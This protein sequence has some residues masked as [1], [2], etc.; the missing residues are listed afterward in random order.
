MSS[1]IERVNAF[2]R[3]A[4][5]SADFGVLFEALCIDLAGAGV[6]LWRV[7]IGHRTLDPVVRAHSDVWERGGGVSRHVVRH[8][9]GDEQ[10]VQS[11]IHFLWT[12]Q[13]T[14]GRWRLASGEDSGLDLLVDMRKR[15]GTDYVMHIAV[16]GPDAAEVDG[17]A[18]SFATDRPGGFSDDDLATIAAFVPAL[19]LASARAIASD[20]ARSTLGAY[21]GPRSA[22]LVLDGEIR[23]GQG[24]RAEAAILLTDLRGFTRLTDGTDPLAVVAWLDH[25][26]EAIV[27][28]IAARG[29]EVLKFMGDGLLAAFPAASRVAAQ[30]AC[31]RALVAARH[32]QEANA[33]LAGPPGAACAPSLDIALHYGEVVY[34]NVGAP[35][36]LDFTVI[37][38]AVNEASRIEALC[39][40][41]GRPILLSCAFARRCDQ[42]TV[43][44]GDHRLR[45]V[46][47][48]QAIF[49]PA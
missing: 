47:Q 48:A 22:Q 8:G 18:I 16:F 10:Y 2:L 21:L 9:E 34:G 31:T 1:P 17:S 45:G 3:R 15:G 30:D 6:P 40:P 25:H 4:T 46:E 23:R 35:D 19:G 27:P 39:E 41:L 5:E 29:G 12:R 37:G 49:A 24:R 44:L 38:R 43:P 32:A 13:R 28:A 42:A 33:A 26:F 20:I 14:F 11:P 36:R 7:A